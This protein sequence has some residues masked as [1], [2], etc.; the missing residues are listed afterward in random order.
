MKK[1][2][3]ITLALLATLLLLA[4]VGL[5]VVPAIRLAVLER[6]TAALRDGILDRIGTAIRPG[7]PIPGARPPVAEADDPIATL[8]AEGLEQE[9]ASF[10]RLRQA[11]ALVEPKPR[12]AVRPVRQHP[13]SDDEATALDAWFSTHHLLSV[14]AEAFTR[15][16]YRSC[17]PGVATTAD[18]APCGAGDCNN[19]WLDPRSHDALHYAPA[20]ACR[21]LLAFRRGDVTDALADLAR[22]QGIVPRLLREPTLIGGLF[23]RAIATLPLHMGVIQARLDLWPDDALETVPREAETI[24]RFFETRWPDIL[25]GEIL[26]IEANLFEIPIPSLTLPWSDAVAPPW[27]LPSPFLL[28][29]WAT[30]GWRTGYLGYLRLCGDLAVALGDLSA[31]PPSPGRATAARIISEDLESHVCN[32][33]YAFLAALLPGS[34]A[35]SFLGLVQAPRND[36]IIIRAATA[37]ERYRRAH[38]TLPP[39]LANLVPDYLPTLPLDPTTGDPIPYVPGPVA[40]PDEPVHPIPDNPDI[41]PYDPFNPDPPPPPSRILPAATLPGFTLGQH[42]FHL[43]AN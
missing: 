10:Q 40:I 24:A 32:G 22:I 33:D 26:V 7:T 4:V 15:P 28:R 38:G 27:I 34:T 25:A 29:L 8:D 43:P 30:C 12:P 36:A 21:A 41:D 23:A 16:D 39:D 3:R 9:R 6:R 13:L 31:L 5:A 11:F 35:G 17:L 19:M 42:F 2:L 14:A 20:L 1:P 37:I 18:F